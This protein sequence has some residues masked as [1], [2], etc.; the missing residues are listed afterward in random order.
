[1]E[2]VVRIRGKVMGLLK[3]IHKIRRYFLGVAKPFPAAKPMAIP[4]QCGMGLLLQ[5]SVVAEN[6]FCELQKIFASL[7]RRLHL[8]QTLLEFYGI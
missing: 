3:E 4:R 7:A 6:A 2:I 5:P 1:M 8:A